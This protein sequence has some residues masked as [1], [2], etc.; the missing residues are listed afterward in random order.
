MQYITTLRNVGNACEHNSHGYDNDTVDMDISSVESVE[1][2]IGEIEDVVNE[3]AEETLELVAI[4]G[5]QS[6]SIPPMML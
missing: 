6:V 3:S 1:S 5:N 4:S 2:D